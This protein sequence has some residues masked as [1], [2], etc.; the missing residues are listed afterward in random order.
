MHEELL[1]VVRSVKVYL[2]DIYERLHY[3]RIAF[4]RII[5]I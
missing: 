1:Q 5:I 2:L 4:I 3:N